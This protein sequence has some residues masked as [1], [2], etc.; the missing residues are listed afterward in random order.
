MPAACSF[1]WGTCKSRG[2]AYAASVLDVVVGS[3]KSRNRL[4]FEFCGV[5]V[6]VLLL[7]VC[8][9]SLTGVVCACVRVCVRA[10]LVL[11]GK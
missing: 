11:L 6:L 8:L 9:L 4:A 10:M 7:C 5:L 1:V 2:K 3:A